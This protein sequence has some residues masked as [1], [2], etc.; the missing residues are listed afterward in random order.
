LALVVTLASL[1]FACVAVVIGV[2]TQSWLWQ[3]GLAWVGVLC[4]LTV[5]V[6]IAVSVLNHRAGRAPG[7][8]RAWAV[9]RKAR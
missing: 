1:P 7:V 9:V 3:V 2:V 5:V 4:V 6:Q 8:P